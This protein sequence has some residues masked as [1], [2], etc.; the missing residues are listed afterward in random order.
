MKR[1][2]FFLKEIAKKHLLIIIF[3]KNTE[4]GEIAKLKAKKVEEIYTKAIAEKFIY[5]KKQI[6][7]ELA[8]YGI[9]SILTDPAELS[10]NTINK[11]LE[12]KAKS[13]I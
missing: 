12:I 5:E 6:I 4:L 3:F 7:K 13:L 10:I 1:K 9:H 8:R 2:L 11:Y